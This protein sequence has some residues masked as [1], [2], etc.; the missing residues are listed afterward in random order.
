M[1]S[2]HVMRKWLAYTI[3]ILVGSLLEL[4]GYAARIVG[5]NDP[6]FSTGWILQ[7]AIITFAPVFMSAAL[8]VCIGRIAD[9]IGRGLF[10]IKPRLYSWV[11][12]PSD[13]LA[14]VVQGAGG[15]ISVTESVTATGVTPGAAIV[16]AGLTF[17]VTSLTI[18]FILF[19][20]V[21]WPS[22]IWYPKSSGLSIYHAKRLRTFV[23][24]IIISILLIIGR[25]AFRVAELSQ[26]VRGSLVHDELLFIIFDSFPIAIATAI[27]VT[28]H[29]VFML[30]TEQHKKSNSQEMELLSGHPAGEGCRASTA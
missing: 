9:F 3:A 24:C 8:Y 20:A 21:L 18:F 1:R 14:L 16:I 6:W 22:S 28:V 7:Y 5:Y 19:G 12:I 11:F 23:I 13:F 10:N 15:A 4:V 30:Q 2:I 25:S 17:Q 29:P 26:G 27:M